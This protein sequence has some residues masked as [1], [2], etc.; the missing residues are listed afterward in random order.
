MSR[1]LTRQFVVPLTL[2][3]SLLAGAA[4]AFWSAGSVPG[5][6]GSATA[7]SVNQGSTPTATASGRTVT[8]SWPATTLSN[9]TAVS[10]Y[11]IKRYDAATLTTQTVLAGCSGTLTTTTCAETNLPPGQWVY[12][13]TPR[14]AT[15]WRGPE[16]VKSV[17]VT[18]APPVLSFASSI[19]RPTTSLSGT[20]AGFLG[21]ETVRYRLDSV[22]GTEL[23]GTLAGNAT[24]ATVPGSGE[25][26]VSVTIP[27]G[28]TEGAHTV[29]AV[30]SP[31]GDTAT[32]GI[33]VDSTPP[34]I[35]VLTVTP[36][37]LSGDAATFAYTEA[38]TTATV[39][40][41]LDSA[42]FAD[43]ENPTSYTGLSAGAHTFQARAIDTVGNVSSSTTHAWTVDLSIPTVDITFPSVA[44]MYNDAGF[45][46]GCSNTAAGASRL[47]A[48]R[49]CLAA[50]SKTRNPALL[51]YS[52]AAQSTTTAPLSLNAPSSRP[53]NSRQLRL[54]SRPTGPSTMTLSWRCS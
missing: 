45:T 47:L 54:S 46:S 21:G 9:G 1:G 24:P 5:G 42:T 49:A 44:G 11:T 33:T 17:A 36:S 14:I 41:R 31:S 13:V 53:S 18:V 52:I 34:P 10:G 16:S 8:V 27:S 35:P 30:A 28:T 7:S 4:W 38:E 12:S 6:N 39:E 32:T 26:T 29:Y 25:G 50:T 15:N 43:C 19:V 37:T 22:T 48:A 20:A 40:C 3:L 2:L 51:M 23:T